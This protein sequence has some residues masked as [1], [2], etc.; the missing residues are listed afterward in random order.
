MRSL[1]SRLPYDDLQA[2]KGFNQRCKYQ[3]AWSTEDAPGN[4]LPENQEADDEETQF[5]LDYDDT[6]FDI[7]AIRKQYEQNGTPELIACR[8][9]P[10]MT[11]ASRISS[12]LIYQDGEID[13]DGKDDQDSECLFDWLEEEYQK[14]RR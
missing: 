7:Q 9:D 3:S 11:L 14:Q 1:A 13:Q 6:V 8:I 5:S 2:S 10:R 4:R 12:R